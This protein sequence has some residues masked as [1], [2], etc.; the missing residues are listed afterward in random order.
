MKQIGKLRVDV[1]DG[2]RMIQAYVRGDYTFENLLTVTYGGQDYKGNFHY[3]MF[4]RESLRAILLGAG[5]LAGEYATVAR[6]NGLCLEMEIEA[7]KA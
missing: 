1:L 3:T 4:S 7:K 5:F 2:E 6:A